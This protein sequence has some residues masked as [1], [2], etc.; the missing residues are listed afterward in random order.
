MSHRIGEHYFADKSVL[1]Q[2]PLGTIFYNPLSY[3]LFIHLAGFL[4]H[5]PLSEIGKK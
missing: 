4:L 1:T 3:D 5:P 2:F